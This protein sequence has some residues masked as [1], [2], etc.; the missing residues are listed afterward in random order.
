MKKRSGLII[1]TILLIVV[2]AFSQERTKVNSPAGARMLLGKRMLS[3]QWISWE[4]FG[5][6]TVTNTRGVYRIK[7]EQKGRGNSDLL[8]ID[9]YISSID[10]KEFTFQGTIITQISHINDGEP[11]TREGE[12][13]FRIT[14][15][16]KYWRLMQ[17]DNPCDQATDYIDIYFRR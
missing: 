16:R 9:G 15:N 8:R 6:A 12:F 14:G 4:H 11:C 5:T 7:G 3:L 2:P 1:F 10:A 13:V 17:M